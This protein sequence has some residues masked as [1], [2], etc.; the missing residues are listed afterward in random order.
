M[1]ALVMR[2][3]TEN[4]M[5]EIERLCTARTAPVAQ[6]QRARLLRSLAQDQTA[7]KAARAVGVTSETARKLLKRFNEAGLKALQDR[8]RSGRRRVLTEE[9]RGKL[10][11][12]AQS[13]P[14]EVLEGVAPG[15]HW[16]LATL[17]QAAR[18]EGIA[19]SQMH[20]G[21]ILHQEGMRW[22]RRGRSWLVSPDPELPEKRGRLWAST[23]IPQRG[24]W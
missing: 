6:V 17:Q 24:A 1:R 5:K 21:R 19:I 8:P 2:P 4:E 20:L 3:P 14:E 15:C 16:T 18:Q 9:A 23:P 11:F 7:P 13:R 22:W 10:M 12:L